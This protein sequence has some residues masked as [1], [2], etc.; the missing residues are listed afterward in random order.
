MKP[1]NNLLKLILFGLFILTIS[2]STEESCSEPGMV[3]IKNNDDTFTRFFFYLESTSEI[4]EIKDNQRRPP[5]FSI[6]KGESE[7]LL[8]EPGTYLIYSFYFEGGCTRCYTRHDEH[9]A[10]VTV[11]NCETITIEFDDF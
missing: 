8:L 4:S 10:E 5:D 1:Q 11:T 3:A 9:T 7:K 6:K 2:C